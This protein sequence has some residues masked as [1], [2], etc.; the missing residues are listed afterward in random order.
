MS[1]RCVRCNRV[2]LGKQCPKCFGVCAR[3]GLPFERAK[4]GRTL[5][6]HCYENYKLSRSEAGKLWGRGQGRQQVGG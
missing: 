6:A 1:G 4:Q 5:C 2:F 3:C